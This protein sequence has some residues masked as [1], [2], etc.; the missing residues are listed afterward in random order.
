[1]FF[2]FLNIFL[3]VHK[4]SGDPSGG[5]VPGPINSDPSGGLVVIDPDVSTEAVTET[6]TDP[7]EP[8]T[9]PPVP[10]NPPATLP[11]DPSTAPPPV[12]TNPP[13][14]VPRIKTD[15]LS[16]L[17]PVP[18][19]PPTTVAPVTSSAP[20]STKAVTNGTSEDSGECGE[21]EICL[22]EEYFEDTF[23]GSPNF[24]FLLIPLA[25]IG[26]W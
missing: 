8:T 24:K 19:D 15:P 2:F 14:T 22:D 13:P 9:Q 25:L 16:T 12:I 5:F 18:T 6:A 4:R 21:D 10:T 23:S 11:P 7:P 20:E 26:F 17:P 3:S 1:M